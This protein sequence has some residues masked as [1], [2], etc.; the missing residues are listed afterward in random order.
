MWRRN[1][2]GYYWINKIFFKIKSQ[3][4]NF[5]RENR[6]RFISNYKVS[7]VI[8]SSVS[9]LNELGIFHTIQTLRILLSEIL[10]NNN[11]CFDI[12]ISHVKEKIISEKSPFYGVLFS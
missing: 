12:I 5:Y 8:D 6:D 11:L 7:F 9:C 2:F 10:Y 1:S 4:K 3:I